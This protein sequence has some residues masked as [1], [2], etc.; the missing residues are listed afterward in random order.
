[1]P[2]LKQNNTSGKNS[3]N[4]VFLTQ[5]SGRNDDKL[6]LRRSVQCPT[7]LSL[8]SLSQEQGRLHLSCS[9]TLRKSG[10]APE[11]SFC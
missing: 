2:V 1:M 8:A 4:R 6:Y 9:F 5:D 11:L 3:F 7:S 10:T